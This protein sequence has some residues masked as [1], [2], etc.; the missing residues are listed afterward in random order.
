M[1]CQTVISASLW[2]SAPLDASTLTV[3]GITTERT[4]P[5]AKLSNFI[6]L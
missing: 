2:H 1:E 3:V 6:V 4:N 5:Y